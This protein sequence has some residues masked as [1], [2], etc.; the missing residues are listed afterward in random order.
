VRGRAGAGRMTAQPHLTTLIVAAVIAAGALHAVWN[1]IAK[2][3]DD[4]LMAFAVMGIPMTVVGMTFLKERFGARRI[5]AAA[6]IA[7]GVVLIST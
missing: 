3:L 6:V 5:A 2:H 4:R 7:A 1:A